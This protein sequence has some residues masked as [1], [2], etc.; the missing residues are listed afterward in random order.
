MTISLRSDLTL[1]YTCILGIDN[2][3]RIDDT[4]K[5]DF[6]ALLTQYEAKESFTVE[7]G[8]SWAY[9]MTRN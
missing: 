9:N 1:I 4:R 6:I 8:V 7:T 5:V 2:V 3:L